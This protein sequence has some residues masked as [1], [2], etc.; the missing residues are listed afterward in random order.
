MWVTKETFEKFGVDSSN[1]PEG[2]RAH[3]D[4]AEYYEPNFLDSTKDVTV[5]KERMV[6]ILTELSQIYSDLDSGKL[7]PVKYFD[8]HM[9]Q[10]HIDDMVAK[11][12]KW[13]KYLILSWL[14]DKIYVK[15]RNW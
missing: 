4:L 9:P 15:I 12:W 10:C 5:S 11:N 2:F 14:H 3:L 8:K 1:L 7:K 6:R 13:K